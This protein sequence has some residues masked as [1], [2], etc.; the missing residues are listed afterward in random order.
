MLSISPAIRFPVRILGKH[1]VDAGGA[2]ILVHGDSAW[3]LVTQLDL[4]SA[5]DYV[6][7]RRQQGF[8]SFIV[9]LIEDHVGDGW[10]RTASG[11]E[12]FDGPTFCRPNSDYFD[13][14]EAI[15]RKTAD[16][17]ALL[18][19]VPVYLGYNGGS[20]GFY[21]AM[22]ST[23][24]DNL[25]AYGRYV[26]ERFRSLPN[27]VWVNGGDYT[28]PPDGLEAVRGIV[29]GIKETDPDHLHTAHWGRG[30]AA[31]DLAAELWDIN[32]TYAKPPIK[33][34]CLGDYRRNPVA[35]VLIGATTRAGPG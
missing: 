3:S 20:E 15:L 34:Q 9:Q 12:P 14:A 4:K 23:S 25:R 5:A 29:F 2:P 10:P 17:G 13:H 32:A 18:F 31:F 11:L 1:I 27:V 26:G 6:T 8:N 30:S 22:T 35:R 33:A 16:A 19:L 21:Q 24:T 7:A 28:P